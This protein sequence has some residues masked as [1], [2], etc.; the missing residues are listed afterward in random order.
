MRTHTL[1]AAAWI[2]AYGALAGSPAHNARPCPIPA[3]EMLP[4]NPPPDVPSPAERAAEEAHWRSNDMAHAEEREAI[5]ELVIMLA[6]KSGMA[7]NG[8]DSY[9]TDATIRRSAILRAASM[10]TSQQADP[11]PEFGASATGFARRVKSDEQKI[12]GRQ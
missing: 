12:R 3:L 5:H 2:I 4:P 6:S 11:W 1:L 7:T 8:L 9:D 10:I